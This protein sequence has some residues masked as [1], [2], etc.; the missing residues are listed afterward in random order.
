MSTSDH[1]APSF[2]KL[3]LPPVEEYHKRKVA[4]ISGEAASANFIKRPTLDLF[5]LRH[6][7]T[8]RVLFVSDSRV[9][10]VNFPIKPAS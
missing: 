2:A 4:L 10:Q 7:W 6:H 8:G 5:V 3:N 1:I 9:L